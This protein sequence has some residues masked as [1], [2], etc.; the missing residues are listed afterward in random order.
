MVIAFEVAG[1][2]QAAW[3]V[4]DAVQIFFKTAN[5]GDVRSTIRRLNPL[6][7]NRI[8]NVPA[9]IDMAV[10]TQLVFL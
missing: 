6:P 5:F 4:I 9:A 10:T 1:G 8:S 7:V 2:V 3:K